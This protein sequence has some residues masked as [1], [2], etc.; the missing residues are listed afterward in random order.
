MKILLIIDHF[1]SGGAQ[2]QLTTL[3]RGLAERGHAVSVFTYH[4]KQDFFRASLERSG[5]TLIDGPEGG[6]LRDRLRALRQVMKDGRFDAALS[7]LRM[8][9]LLCELAGTLARQPRLFVSER[10]SRFDDGNPVMARFQRELHRLAD[11]VIT[12]SPDHAAWLQ[13]RYRHLRR[14][15]RVILNGYEIPPEPAIAP[16]ADP[17]QLKLLAIAR[18]TP[19]KQAELLIQG[20][21][22]FY[23]AHGWVPRTTWVGRHEATGADHDYAEAMKALLESLPHVAAAWTWG[24]ERKDIAALIAEHHLLVHPALHEGFSNVI[25]E[26]LM[27]ARPVIASNVCDHPFLMNQNA[28]GALFA[29]DDPAEVMRCVEKYARMGQ[30]EYRSQCAAA[31]VFAIR[32]FSIDRFIAE[33]ETILAG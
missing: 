33:H 19:L 23:Q 18:L 29:P 8:P 4:R 9:N 10:S 15:T 11:G 21:D 17:R 27:Q 30:D 6:G 13:G 28:H 16:P 3:A 24:G 12:N 22:L 25:C 31:R 1:G 5:I 7:Y 32:H 26:A 14:K 2:T 20:L